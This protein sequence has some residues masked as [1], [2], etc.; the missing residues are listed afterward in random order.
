MMYGRFYSPRITIL[1]KCQ[2]RPNMVFRMALSPDT[3]SFH[4]DTIAVSLQTLCYCLALSLSP[5]PCIVLLSL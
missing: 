3:M 1:L 5:W 2:Q 4:P